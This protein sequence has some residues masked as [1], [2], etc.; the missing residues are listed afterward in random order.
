MKRNLI[1]LGVL[2]LLVLLI[3]LSNH[4]SANKKKPLLFGGVKR[5]KII[6][7]TV[8][9]YNQSEILRK[10]EK[11]WVSTA[12]GEYAADTTKIDELLTAIETQSKDE[13][14]AKNPSRHVDLG[15]DSAGA[16]Q[17][18]IESEK[19]GLQSFFIGNMAHGFSGSYVRLKGEDEV[20]VSKGAYDRL[21]S[22]TQYFYRDKTLFKIAKDQIYDF[23]FSYADADSM[24]KVSAHF[25]AE[26]ASWELLEPEK[27][28]LDNGKVT[29]YLGRI[30]AL[31]VDEW[32]GAE[33]D[34]STGF[35]KPSYRI[36]LKKADGTSVTLLAGVEKNGN[37]YVRLEGDDNRYL[38]KKYRFEGLRPS[39]N[40]LKAA[41]AATEGSV[42]PEGSAPMNIPSPGMGN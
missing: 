6:Q 23:E 1:L 22:T 17:V 21:F 41:P 12:G 5:D 11:G 4:L 18:T 19:G 9:K 10:T 25:S 36:F 24:N 3:A 40:D 26:S 27:V 8:A 14:V 38:I 15:V 37:Y 30:A 13:P 32:Y 31:N 42:A 29:E 16:T 35:A 7:I 33:E 20:Y 39:V 2:A 28:K 34:T